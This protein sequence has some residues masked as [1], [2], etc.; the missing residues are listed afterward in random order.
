MPQAI[1]HALPGLT[2]LAMSL[3]KDTSLIFL[4]GGKELMGITQ[5]EAISSGKIIPLYIAAMLIYL[6]ICSVT[7]KIMLH[8]ASNNLPVEAT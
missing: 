6:I 8:L 2:N 7:E 5:A 1:K 4:I 3:V